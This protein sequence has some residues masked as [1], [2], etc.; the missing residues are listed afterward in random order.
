MTTSAEPTSQRP[1]RIADAMVLIAALFV[2]LVWDRARVLGSLI[3]FPFRLRN[4]FGASFSFGYLA[5]EAAGLVLLGL[6][7]VANII[8]RTVLS[9]GASAQRS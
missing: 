5:S 3:G 2:A 9:G 8:V 6:V 7:L 1:F 4:L